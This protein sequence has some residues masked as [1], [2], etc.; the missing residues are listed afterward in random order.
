MS[1]GT[2][3]PSENNNALAELALALATALWSFSPSRAPLPLYPYRRLLSLLLA[4]RCFG[5][6][7]PSSPSVLTDPERTR[8][9]VL[10]QYP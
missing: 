5:N 1:E 2:D 9:S 3:R 10:D 6:I 8:P 4:G 7:T